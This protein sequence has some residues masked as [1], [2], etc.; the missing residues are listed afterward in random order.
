MRPAMFW[1][2][3]LFSFILYRFECFVTWEFTEDR[4]EC[5]V[6]RHMEI[7][8]RSCGMWSVSSRGDSLKIVWNVECF[9]T[10]GFTEDRVECGVFR[11]VGSHWRSC[12]MWSVSSRGDSLKIA[13]NVECFFILISVI[14]FRRVLQNCDVR[15]LASLCL[16]LRPHGKTRFCFAEFSWNFIFE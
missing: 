15:L 12:G 13:W 5:G 9:V 2:Q 11:H 6:F 7:H 16:S 8:W 4:V 3:I 10:W 1:K 14:T